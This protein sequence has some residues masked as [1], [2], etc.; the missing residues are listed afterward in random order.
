MIQGVQHRRDIMCRIFHPF[1]AERN[2]SDDLSLINKENPA[3]KNG[4]IRMLLCQIP[5][6][7]IKRG[8]DVVIA[9]KDMYKMPA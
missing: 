3:C 8:F 6:Y 1:G 4:T 2:P 5:K 7:R 9:M